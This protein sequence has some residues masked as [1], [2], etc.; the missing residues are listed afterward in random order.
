DYF[1][2]RDMPNNIIKT[3]HVNNRKLVEDIENVI[4]QSIR[5]DSLINDK[6]KIGSSKKVTN[7]DA[8]AIADFIMNSN[9]IK[10]NNVSNTKVKFRKVAK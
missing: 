9:S 1:K 6:K 3:D 5:Q 10:K 7:E 4:I 2:I 8:I